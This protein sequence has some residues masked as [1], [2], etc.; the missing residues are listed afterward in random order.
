ML[1]SL[2]KKVT[3]SFQTRRRST[4]TGKM[5]PGEEYMDEEKL[6]MAKFMTKTDLSDSTCLGVV[7]SS[8][9]VLHLVRLVL[10]TM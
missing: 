10:C 7:S 4:L 8:F 1:K 2:V 3:Q 6:R 5:I 9:Q